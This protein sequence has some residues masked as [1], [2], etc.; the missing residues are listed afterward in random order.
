MVEIKYR[1]VNLTV[2]RMVTTLQGNVENAKFLMDLVPSG[3]VTGGDKDLLAASLDLLLLT[4]VQCG[5]DSGE[6]VDKL[7][8][9]YLAM[10]QVR[11]TMQ[12]LQTRFNNAKDIQSEYFK[13]KID[14]LRKKAYLGCIASI[15]GGPLGVA[16]CYTAAVIIIE[17]QKVP[18]MQREIETSNEMMGNFTTNF[19]HL[20]ELAGSLENDT[21]TKAEAVSEFK[22]EVDVASSFVKATKQVNVAIALREKYLKLLEELK[23]ACTSHFLIKLA[24]CMMLPRRHVICWQVLTTQMLK[25]QSKSFSWT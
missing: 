9:I 8:D 21:A 10:A 20:E 12:A 2:T 18:A 3:T 11:A 6:Q 15:V 4:L 7:G 22:S 5:E 25:T 14:E 13:S 24:R 23:Q 19:E 16:A 17:T 1:P